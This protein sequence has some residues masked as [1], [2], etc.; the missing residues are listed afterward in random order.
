[1]KSSVGKWRNPSSSLNSTRISS[2]YFLS[3][4]EEVGGSPYRF[5]VKIFG[6]FVFW[7]DRFGEEMREKLFFGEMIMNIMAAHFLL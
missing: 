2:G 1:M 5:Q 6:H 4:P 3:K 7:M